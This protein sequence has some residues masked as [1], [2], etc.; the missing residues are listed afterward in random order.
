MYLKSQS[1][2]LSRKSP[3]LLNEALQV[4]DMKEVHLMTF[5]RN[6]MGY[7]LNACS[8]ALNL[9]LPTSANLKIEERS[10]FLSIKSMIIM[11]VLA[12]ME[13]LFLKKFLRMLDG[14]NSLIIECH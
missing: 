7:L 8:Q 9:L 3:A 12:E 5:G 13:E 14:D 10:S 2:Q 4:L 1:F 11:H 6:R